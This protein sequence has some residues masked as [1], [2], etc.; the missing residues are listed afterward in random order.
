MGQIGDI[1]SRQLHTMGE[2]TEAHYSYTFMRHDLCR[3]LL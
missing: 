2:A 1:K 3:C